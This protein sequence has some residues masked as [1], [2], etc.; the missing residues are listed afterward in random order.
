MRKIS[1]FSLLC[2]NMRWSRVIHCSFQS[3]LAT[4]SYSL[5]FVCIQLQV[6]N[7]PEI[8]T[9][10]HLTLD[11]HMTFKTI[12]DALPFFDHSSLQ[13]LVHFHKHCHNK[14]LTFFKGFVNG[15][16]SLSK[17]WFGCKA[18]WKLP[19]SNMVILAGWLCDFV[20]Q[21]IESLKET[22]TNPFPTPSS[23]HKEF[24]EFIS[25]LLSHVSQDLCSSFSKG[26]ATEGEAFLDQLCC[27]VS[28]IRGGMYPPPPWSL[29]FSHHVQ[30]LL[31]GMHPRQLE[32]QVD[33]QEI[34]I[35]DIECH[36]TVTILSY[37]ANTMEL[38][39]LLNIWWGSKVYL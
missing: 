36:V 11:H 8:K 35:A 39:Y 29:W 21:Y 33:I 14:L 18:T 13:D 26:Y 23:L 31:M 19:Q 2:K 10:A 38:W 22:Y 30:G 3:R 24:N 15:R 37:Y 25:N 6:V 34:S 16:D 1:L 7:S 20:F 12:G 27:K 32:C 4:A 9:T 17:I 5:P 28:K